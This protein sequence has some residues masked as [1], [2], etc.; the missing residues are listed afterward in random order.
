MTGGCHM[1]K[2]ISC[3][4]YLSSCGNCPQLNSSSRFDLSRLVFELKS[5]MISSGVQLVGLSN[6]ICD[7]VRRSPLLKNNNV[8]YIPNAIDSVQFSP[9]RKSMAKKMLGVETK[10]KII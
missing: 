10:K 4:N 5:R 3:D 1:A 2:A 6:W 9:I 8:T 7:E